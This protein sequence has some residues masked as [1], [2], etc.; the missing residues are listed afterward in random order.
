MGDA[1]VTV[2]DDNI[3]WGNFG[4]ETGYENTKRI[5]QMT[6]RPT[7]LVAGNNFIAIGI[8]HALSES[9]I[10]V[11][12]DMALVSFDEFPPGLTIEPFF[13][14]V[15][16]PA[17]QMGYQAAELLLSRI[18]GSTSNAYQEIV[19]PIEIVVRRSSLQR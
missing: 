19:L 2:N 9:N 15:V 7:A 6:P 5:L 18:S 8:M 17:Y 3:F 11:P 10:H 13:T 1:G 4:H 12:Q 16:Q 14:S